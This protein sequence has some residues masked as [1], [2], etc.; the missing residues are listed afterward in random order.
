MNLPIEKIGGEG[1]ADAMPLLFRSMD[2]MSTGGDACAELQAEEEHSGPAPFVIEPEEIAQRAREQGMQ[3][4][5]A[6]SASQVESRVAEERQGIARALEEFVRER[7]RY[8]AGLEKEVVRLSL[9]IAER[10][11]H[12]EAAMDPMLLAGAA[13]VALEQ[14]QEESEAVLRVPPEQV[15]AWEDTLRKQGRAVQVRADSSLAKGECILETSRGTVELGVRA[16]LQEIEHGFFE[17]L[18]RNPAMA[19]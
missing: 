13:R 7:Q 10:V 16:Q 5:L 8:F 19:V 9:A 6:R 15:T 2:V 4:A 1:A 14:V 12:R 18:G 11:L 3:E 17:L